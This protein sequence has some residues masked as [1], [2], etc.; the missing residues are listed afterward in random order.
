MDVFSPGAKPEYHQQLSAAH[1]VTSFNTWEDWDISSEAP[2][3]IAVEITGQIIV[4]TG[5]MGARSN[6]SS[7]ALLLGGAQYLI[8][9]RMLAPDSSG[10]V[11]VYTS[12][13]TN[14]VN[15]YVTGYWT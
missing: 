11:E 7:D 8:Q 6:G 9:T 2:N 10:I 1:Q 13:A 14:R 15:W 12:A 5:T 3:A 4:G